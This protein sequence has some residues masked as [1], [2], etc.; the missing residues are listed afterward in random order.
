M[1]VGTEKLFN[2]FQDFYKL[3]IENIEMHLI[4]IIKTI[5]LILPII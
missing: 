3:P 4:L 5:I 1:Y 2:K